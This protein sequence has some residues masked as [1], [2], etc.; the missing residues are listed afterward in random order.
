[1]NRKVRND[2]GGFLTRMPTVMRYLI[3]L[4]KEIPLQTFSKS[5]QKFQQKR[6][7]IIFDR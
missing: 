7:N 2:A 1:M 3:V 5:K 6:E 4:H